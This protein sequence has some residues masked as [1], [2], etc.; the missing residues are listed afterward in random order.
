MNIKPRT[1]TS[2]RPKNV[3]PSLLLLALLSHGIYYYDVLNGTYNECLP[4]LVS[5]AIAMICGY[6]LSRCLKPSWNRKSFRNRKIDKVNV[7]RL[8]KISCVFWIIGVSAHIYYYSLNPIQGYADS[9]L[10]SRGLG[11]ITVFF[12]FWSISIILNEYLISRYQ[13]SKKFI[14]FTRVNLLIFCLLYFF[15]FMKRRQIIFLFLAVIAVWG[16]KLKISSRWLIYTTGFALVIL[17]AVFGRVRGY[18]VGADLASTVT[19]AINNFSL[20][21]FTPDEFEGKF[22]SRTLNDINS[23]VQFY[24]LNP[25]VLIGVIC[26]FIPNALMGGEAPLAFPEWYASTF[27]PT[28]YALGAG[29][30]GSMV[31]ELYLVGGL[32]L[33]IVGYFLIGFISARIEVRNYETNDIIGNLVYAVFVYTLLLLPRYDLASLLIDIV[34]TYMPLVFAVHFSQGQRELNIETHKESKK[35]SIR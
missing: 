19:Y 20:S 14:V 7:T 10:S 17:F 5:A 23:Y 1:L 9:Y 24:G 3:F 32:V 27:Y 29:F 13:V 16:P 31:A 26:V 12:S 25:S 34:F 2:S 30:A 22:I 35:T 6:F 15:I 11:F 33:L 28:D 21:W 4:L 18:Y 8:Q